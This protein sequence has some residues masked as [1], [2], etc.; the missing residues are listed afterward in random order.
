MVLMIRVLRALGN[1]CLT[2]GLTPQISWWK[3]VPGLHTYTYIIYIYT[4]VFQCMQNY[5]LF[6]NYCWRH[7]LLPPKKFLQFCH[8][9]CCCRFWHGEKTR[10]N[11]EKTRPNGE[12]RQEAK[13]PAMRW[14]R[15]PR[16]IL[17]DTKWLR[18]V[19]LW[20]WCH[21]WDL[22]KMLPFQASMS[23]GD[24]LRWGCKT[25]MNFLWHVC[26]PFLQQRRLNGGKLPSSRAVLPIYGCALAPV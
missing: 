20:C 9:A 7:F 10:R 5:C 18:I 14:T 1:A 25:R 15:A 24:L 3:L 23:S 22:V 13:L 26:I 4:C 8:F 2:G 11:G 12:K 21:A 6:R 16:G 19:V 17:I